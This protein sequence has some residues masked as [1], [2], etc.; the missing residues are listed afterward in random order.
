MEQVAEVKMDGIRV[1][2]ELPS[3]SEVLQNRIPL[4]NDFQ[5]HYV[6]VFYKPSI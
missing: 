3:T 1:Q 2:V 6:D 4:V 5:D